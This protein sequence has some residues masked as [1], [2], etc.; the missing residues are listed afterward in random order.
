MSC[1][2]WEHFDLGKKYQR[3]TLPLQ[4]P[5][6]GTRLQKSGLHKITE[7]VWWLLKGVLNINCLAGRQ[8][9]VRQVY[10]T[11]NCSTR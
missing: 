2:A 1:C 5:G 8:A 9:K 7:R 10:L 6:S 11:L 4:G 3:S